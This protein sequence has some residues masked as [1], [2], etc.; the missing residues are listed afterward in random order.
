[1]GEADI[2][3]MITQT[4]L[5]QITGRGNLVLGDQRNLSWRNQQLGRC[6]ELEGAWQKH[7]WQ[8]EHHAQMLYGRREHGTFSELQGGKCGEGQGN[9]RAK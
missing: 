5:Q 2:N 9:K 3:Q 1:M 6:L 8:G 4:N 7:R